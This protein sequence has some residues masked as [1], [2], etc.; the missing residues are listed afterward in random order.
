[1]VGENSLLNDRLYELRP[2]TYSNRAISQ[3]IEKQ[4]QF[5]KNNKISL[6]EIPFLCENFLKGFIYH[7]HKLENIDINYK[8]I[9]SAIR[10]TNGCKIEA[11]N[12][13]KTHK[14]V[15]GNDFKFKLE[16][17][18]E[19][20]TIL[21][22]GV[23]QKETDGSIIP[24]LGIRTSS[25]YMD[26]FGM[27]EGYKHQN[28]EKGVDKLLG[29]MNNVSF[30]SNG[31]FNKKN[32]ERL[33]HLGINFYFNFERIHPFNDGNGRIG[34]ILLLRLLCNT[35]FY[36]F[37]FSEEKRDKHMGVF[38]RTISGGNRNLF[39]DFF[40]KEYRDFLVDKKV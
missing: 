20:H 7:N 31:N 4:N 19:A 8:D 2:H 29:W 34:R 33:L 14:F 23:I 3:I 25:I 11:S 1:M 12:S 15:F 22:D 18:V 16:N 38:D 36:P 35:G 9:N 5:Y 6:F 24:E 28:I 37:Y 17:L 32:V 21:M 39:S 30:N 40:I 13:M 10:N 27:F 26:S